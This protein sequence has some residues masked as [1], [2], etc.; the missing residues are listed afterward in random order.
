MSYRTNEPSDVPS[1][2]DHQL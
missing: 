1:V 2:V